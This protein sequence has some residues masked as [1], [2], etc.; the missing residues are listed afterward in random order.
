MKLLLND[1]EIIQF[2]EYLSKKSIAKDARKKIEEIQ[3]D[4]PELEE[5]IIRV[6]EKKQ[7]GKI[8]KFK[9]KIPGKI[10]RAVRNDLNVYL[11]KVKIIIEELKNRRI[12]VIRKKFKFLIKK[13]GEQEI[14]ELYRKTSG[15]SG[16]IKSVGLQIDPRS[17][18]RVRSDYSNSQED[19][20]MRN[21][22]GN[23]KILV[24]KIDN[25]YPF[26]FIDSGYTNFL[27][28]K[29]KVWHRLT[30]NHIHQTKNF[31]PPTD[32]LGIFKEFPK[33]WRFD[34]EYI[35][36]IE[37]GPF[38]AAIFHVDMQTWKYEIEKEIRKYSDKPIKF[39]PKINKKIR[40]P[41]Y[42]ELLNEDYYCVININSNAATESIWA[43][44]PVITLDKH[45]T[46]S[47]SRNSISEINNLYR[48]HLANWLCMLSYSQFTYEEL[49]NGT[50]YDIIK[51]YHV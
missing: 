11:E 20:L 42:Q 23:E 8:E 35:L 51:K 50:A 4:E 2:L 36:V 22:I 6:L 38:S 37:P 34:G 7:A 18:F 31:I 15:A 49:I 12:T 9:D 17:E 46:N 10:E 40:K 29:H 3:F 39:R 30:K 1:K 25:N 19:C 32:R 5:V 41:L 26:W 48:P 33:Q 21:T 27:E 14:F 28:G 45:I 43:G 16:F 24:E 13:F 44:V 47:V